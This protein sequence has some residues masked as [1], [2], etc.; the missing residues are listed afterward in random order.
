MG[1]SVSG[2]C[3]SGL[4]EPADHG[5]AEAGSGNQ[6][7]HSLPTPVQRSPFASRNDRLRPAGHVHAFA[8]LCA[9]PSQIRIHG[10]MAGRS[11][12]AAGCE[13]GQTAIACCHEK[14][15]LLK[16]CHWRLIYETAYCGIDRF[17]KPCVR[18]SLYGSLMHFHTAQSRRGD[19]L[20]H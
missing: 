3:R 20:F 5:A 6:K 12:E 1:R 18:V 10:N 14:S 4:R 17:N 13:A 2:R 7:F 11:G 9:D 15:V 8:S 16:A 19:R